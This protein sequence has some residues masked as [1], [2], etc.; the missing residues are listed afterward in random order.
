VFEKA[1]VDVLE[2]ATEDD[3]MD[4]LLR[5]ADMRKQSQRRSA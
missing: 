2:L 3:V 4:A 5:F 1:G